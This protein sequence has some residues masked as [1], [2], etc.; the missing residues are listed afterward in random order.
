M[1]GTA[2]PRVPSVGCYRAE[3]PYPAL[4]A[5]FGAIYGFE[6]CPCGERGLWGQGDAPI[7]ARILAR[8]TAVRLDRLEAQSLMALFSKPPAKKPSSSSSKPSKPAA[9]PARSGHASARELAAKAGAKAADRPKVEPVPADESITGASLAEWSPQPQA[10]EVA[11]A[12]PGLCAVL[13]NAALLYA[14]GQAPGARTLLEQGVATDHDTKQSSLAWLALFDLLQRAGDRSAFD[15]LALQYSVQFERSAPGWEG[16]DGAPA[17]PKA[18]GGYLSLG[19]KLTADSALQIEGLRKAIARKVAHAKLDLSTVV[20]FD[21][22]GARLLAAALAEARRAKLALTLDRPQKLK[23]ALDAAVKNGHAGGEG[24]W[25]LSLELLQWAHHQATFDDRAIEY[26]IA[27]EMSPPSWEP[28]PLAIAPIEAAPAEQSSAGSRPDGEVVNLSGVLTG[29]SVQ[30]MLQDYAQSRR[31]VIVDMAAVE[32]IDFVCA[33]SMLNAVNRIE[34]Q[35][36]AVQVLGASPIIRAL[37]LLI[38]LSPRHFV[39]KAV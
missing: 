24:A 16:R 31:V 13:E 20:G 18:A 29:H 37:L 11:Q 26:A 10:I 6:R 1:A 28:P 8:S 25:L 7:I 23:A 36:K 22:P 5:R 38:G 12:N 32:R 27:F 2:A 14:S 35:R 30:G 33:G 4:R 3:L 34:S 39:K 9:T 19:G 15:Q 21:D 17:A